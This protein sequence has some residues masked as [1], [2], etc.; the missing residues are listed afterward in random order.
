M[1]QELRGT[2]RE[3]E[4]HTQQR[5]FAELVGIFKCKFSFFRVEAFLLTSETSK[6][7]GTEKC[8]FF[9]FL[10]TFSESKL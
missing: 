7:A 5:L 8:D 4:R 9:L 2:E 10:N 3:R 1:K 6:Q